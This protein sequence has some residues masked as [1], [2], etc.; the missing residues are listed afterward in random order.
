MMNDETKRYLDRLDAWESGEDGEI[1][2]ALLEE[3]G[4]AMPPDVEL[5]DDE[6]HA[7]LWQ[8]IR[9]IAELGMYLENTDHLSDRQLYRYLREDALLVPEFLDPDDVSSATHL[10]PIGG[11]SEEDIIIYLKYYAD[12]QTR[13][14]WR[15]NYPDDALPPKLPLPYD[16]DRLLPTRESRLALRPGA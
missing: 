1:P 2:L 5:G 12:E 7:R 4:I 13:A 6:L 14:D 9:G 15:R 8:V 16:R 3:I 11:C 10:S